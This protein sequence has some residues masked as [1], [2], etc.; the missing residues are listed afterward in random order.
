MGRKACQ[1]AFPPFF[2]HFSTL[3]PAVEGEGGAISEWFILL[4]TNFINATPRVIFL[5]GFNGQ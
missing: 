4:V 2:K 1:L 3:N 5:T